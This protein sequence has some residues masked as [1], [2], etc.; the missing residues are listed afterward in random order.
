[1][2]VKRYVVPPDESKAGS[3]VVHGD[4]GVTSLA[5][6]DGLVVDVER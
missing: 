5:G 2:D 1:M 4:D 6:F 3:V